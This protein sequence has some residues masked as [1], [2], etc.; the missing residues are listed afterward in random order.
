MTTDSKSCSLTSQ[1][2]IYSAGW[3]NQFKKLRKF[4][5]NTAFVVIVRDPRAARPYLFSDGQNMYNGVVLVCTVN[6]YSW[7]RQLIIRY[8]VL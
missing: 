1:N 2:I 6:V 7:G 5:Y 8:Q 4:R 3:L